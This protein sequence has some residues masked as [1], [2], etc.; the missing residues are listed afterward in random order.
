M[1]NSHMVCPVTTANGNV[2]YIKYDFRTLNIFVRL[3]Q[4]DDWIFCA[5]MGSSADTIENLVLTAS[6][7]VDTNALTGLQE[8]IDALIAESQTTKDE[9]VKDSNEDSVKKL[10]E[11]FNRIALP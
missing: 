4:N 5:N 1:L 3:S 8:R 11:A 9:V 2:A 10:R 6:K 7:T